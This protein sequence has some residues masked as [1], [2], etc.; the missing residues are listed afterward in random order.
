MLL[1][2]NDEMVTVIFDSWVRLFCD[3]IGQIICTIVVMW[4]KDFLLVRFKSFQ[5]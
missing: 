2:K 5:A 1:L 3:K 4:V